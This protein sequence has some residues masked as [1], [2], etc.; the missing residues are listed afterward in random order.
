MLPAG[1]AGVREKSKGQKRTVADRLFAKLDNREIKGA[2]YEWTAQVLGV[3][4]V[5]SDAWVQVA[6]ASEPS[7]A[8]LLHLSPRATADHALAALQ[9]WSE[10][11][12][13]KRDSTVHVMHIA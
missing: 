8:V 6:S 3:H 5:G 11:P 4:M 12:V 7:C 2:P 9:A 1:H 10:T 13:A